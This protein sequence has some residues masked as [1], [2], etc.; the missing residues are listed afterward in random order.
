MNNHCR[1]LFRFI[2]CGVAVLLPLFAIT[3]SS[4][5]ESSTKSGKEKIYSPEELDNF[6]GV[7]GQVITVEGTLARAG[8]SKSKTVRYLNFSQDYRDTLVL[9]FFVSKG[10]DAF[11]MEKLHKWIG[12]KVRATGKVTEYGSTMQL[13]IEKW[14]QLTEIK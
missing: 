13:E 7:R 2:A 8:E 3:T 5:V 11:A 10:G 9:V 12:K 4:A 1:F 14:D 6:R